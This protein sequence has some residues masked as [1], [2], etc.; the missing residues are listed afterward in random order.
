[1]PGNILSH[2]LLGIVQEAEMSEKRCTSCGKVR[3][4]TEFHGMK[5]APDGH[6]YECKACENKRSAANYLKRKAMKVEQGRET[7]PPSG[8]RHEIANDSA[9]WHCD[10]SLVCRERVNRAMPV[11]CEYVDQDDWQRMRMYG[12][13]ELYAP[14]QSQ[15]EMQAP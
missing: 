4:L 5:A 13:E 15:L 6:R 7:R 12:Y 11:A 1:M 14:L 8:M 10:W 2:V 3:P 9:C